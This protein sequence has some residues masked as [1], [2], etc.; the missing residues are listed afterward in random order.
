MCKLTRCKNLLRFVMLIVFLFV[1]G[2]GKQKPL[3][4]AQVVQN[5]KDLDG[6]T[7][8]VRGLAYLWIDPSVPEMW[9]FGG[10]ALEPDGTLSKQGHVAG[11][12]TLYD[13][14][15]RDDII[16]Y[17]VP[18]DKTGIKISESNFHCEGSFCKMTCSPFTVTSQ[19]TYE[20]VGTLRVN[21]DSDLALEDIDLKQSSQLVDDEQRPIS[22]GDFNVM[23]P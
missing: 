7:I 5:A 19:Q 21:G 12:L 8:R 1:T 2:C 17:G 14:I 13:S 6:K 10:C 16:Q 9:M 18:H 4:V 23:F 22:T 11:W 15:D 3:T 20:F